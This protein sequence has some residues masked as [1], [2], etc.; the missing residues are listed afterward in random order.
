[1]KLTFALLYLPLGALA[2]AQWCRIV[3][4]DV[5]VNCRAGPSLSSR[6]VRTLNPGENRYFSCY[7]RGDCYRDNCTWDK[8]IERGEPDCY[9]NGYL[10]DNHC[11]MGNEHNL[12]RSFLPH[13]RQS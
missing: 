13:V 8:Q 2:T 12:P 9:V 6:V 1:M 5:K 4:S 3:N 11:T 7:K 10:T